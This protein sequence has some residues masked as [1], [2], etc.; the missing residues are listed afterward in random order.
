MF[1]LYRIGL[2]VS[3]A[4]LV[5]IVGLM[6]FFISNQSGAKELF[7]YL[8]HIGSF[9]SGISGVATTGVAFAGVVAWKKQLIQ[10]KKLEVIWEAQVSLRELSLELQNSAMIAVFSSPGGWGSREAEKLNFAREQALERFKSACT[11]LE[12]L[13]IGGF[14][15]WRM[16]TSII[17]TAWSGYYAYVQQQAL[18]GVCVTPLSGEGAERFTKV[19][20]VVHRLERDLDAVSDRY[21]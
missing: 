12:K 10:G 7:D 6:G 1:E 14:G 13:V 20:K 11:Q 8:D 3:V 2:W 4:L 21:S 15:T 17:V 9:L 19:M 16:Q 18:K 5:V